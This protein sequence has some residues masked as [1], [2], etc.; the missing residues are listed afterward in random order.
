MENRI[1][2]QVNEIISE[3][4]DERLKRD[5]MKFYAAEIDIDI[6]DPEFWKKVNEY[7]Q[8]TADEEDNRKPEIC[9]HCGQEIE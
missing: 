5:L 8:K 6:N 2:H 4:V 9:P 1:I 3:V 7:A